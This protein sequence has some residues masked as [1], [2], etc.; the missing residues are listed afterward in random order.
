LKFHIARTVVGSLLL[1]SCAFLSPA[2]AQVA[3]TASPA[4]KVCRPSKLE[5]VVL[6]SLADSSNMLAMSAYRAP[7]AATASVDSMPATVNE[8]STPAD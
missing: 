3:A 6:A 4:A 8:E 1:V 7:K 5:Y 2:S